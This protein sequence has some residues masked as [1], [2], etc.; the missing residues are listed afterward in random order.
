MKNEPYHNLLKK[1]TDYLWGLII[2]DSSFKTGSYL[3]IV[4]IILLLISKIIGYPSRFRTY[5]LA[6]DSILFLSPSYY[7]LLAIPLIGLCCGVMLGLFRKPSLSETASVIDTKLGLNNYL[8]TTLECISKQPPNQIEQLLADNMKKDGVDYLARFSFGY[9]WRAPSLFMILAGIMLVI[10]FV[11]VA[12]SG[13]LDTSGVKTNTFSSSEIPNLITI[14]QGLS[15]IK[16]DTRNNQE[17]QELIRQIE[18][19]L[20][21]LQN[22]KQDYSVILERINRFIREIPNDEKIPAQQ[23][24]Q[25]QSLLQKLESLV[26][27]KISNVNMKE[28]ENNGF[29]RYQ[30]ARLDNR[31]GG[32]ESQPVTPTG[33]EP[34]KGTSPDVKVPSGATSIQA[35]YNNKIETVQPNIQPESHIESINKPYWPEEY[36][37]IIKK[38]FSKE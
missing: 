38:Y 35:K 15:E 16:Q 4:S 5:G 12:H 33:R 23:S 18:T 9:N 25:L 21:D 26:C 3:T 8:P 36:N 10:W 13:V 6:T 14:S 22:T 2:L 28:D 34:L 17:V 32:P 1:I 7:L 11:P 30:P 27:G 29:S 31:S 24:A 37:E 19:L 20:N